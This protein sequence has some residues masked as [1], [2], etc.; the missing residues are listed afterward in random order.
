MKFSADVPPTDEDVPR[1]IAIAAEFRTALQASVSDRD[2][3]ALLREVYV[4]ANRNPT[5]FIRAW[6]WLESH[7]RSSIK[8]LLNT[9]FVT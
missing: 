4:D 9:E 8:R 3:A 7:E 1:A 5:T 2:K 6:Q